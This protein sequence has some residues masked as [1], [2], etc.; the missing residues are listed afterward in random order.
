MMMDQELAAFLASYTPSIEQRVIWGDMH[1]EV[2]SY[3]CADLPPL[4]FITSIRSVLFHNEQVLVVRDPTSHHILPGG[5]V[6]TG[7]SLTDTLRRELLEET[8]WAID[9][10]HY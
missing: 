4:A 5:R 6:E 10:T 1:F 2:K 3:L 8:G 9:N 7:E